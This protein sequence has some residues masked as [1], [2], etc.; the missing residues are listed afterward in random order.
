MCGDVWGLVARERSHAS[1]LVSQA[2][3]SGGQVARPLPFGSILSAKERLRQLEGLVSSADAR[4]AFLVKAVCV[5]R[6]VV[7]VSLDILD[8]SDPIGRDG[9][10]TLDRPPQHT[11]EGCGW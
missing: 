1:L 5:A 8:D 2:V 9:L 11:A 6:Q 3:Q 7:L 4:V 10:N